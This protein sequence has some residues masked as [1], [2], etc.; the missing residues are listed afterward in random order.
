MMGLMFFAAGV[1]TVLLFQQ[2]K[3]RLADYFYP[4]VFGKG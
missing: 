2:L 3:N 4:G 1:I